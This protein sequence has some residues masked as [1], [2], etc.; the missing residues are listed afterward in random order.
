MITYTWTLG[1]L[2]VNLADDGFT[3][4]VY[5][6]NW[7]LTGTDGV[8]NNQFYGSVNVP[9]PSGSFTPYD[10]L[11]EEQVQGWVESALGAEQV[12]SYKDALARQIELQKNPIDAVLPSPWQ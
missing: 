10:D 3:N 6:V 11:T 5:L 4:V 12:A 9:P 1:P 7:A 2:A 8:Y